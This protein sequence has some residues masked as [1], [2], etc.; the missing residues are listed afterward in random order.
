MFIF[1]NKI[2][3]DDEEKYNIPSWTFDSVYMYNNIKLMCLNLYHQ[4][5]K[6]LCKR[7]RWRS[8][9]ELMYRRKS[10]RRRGVHRFS[11][12]VYAPA[13]S[14]EMQL[15][16]SRK[17]PCSSPDNVVITQT[18]VDVRWKQTEERRSVPFI[19]L[20]TVLF[21]FLT[22]FLRIFYISGVDVPLLPRP[23]YLFVRDNS[24]QRC[25]RQTERQDGFCG[26]W[27]LVVCL[28]LCFTCCHISVFFFFMLSTI[29]G[30]KKHLK[31]RAY[32]IINEHLDV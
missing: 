17:F 26:R 11:L 15:A 22:F 10:R 29:N 1:F 2:F 19:L 24:S 25:R 6:A 23:L 7:G 18:S 3:L 4:R 5:A 31:D 32:H 16:G 27:V 13:R 21:F 28:L 9:Q 14:P 30:E 20:I 8:D 12:S